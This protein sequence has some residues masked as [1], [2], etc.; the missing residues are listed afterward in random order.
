MGSAA[1]RRYIDDVT[2]RK[3]GTRP[4]GT[5]LSLVHPGL[6]VDWRD[7]EDGVALVV[8]TSEGWTEQLRVSRVARAAV[9][10]CAG[11]TEFEVDEIPGSLTTQEKFAIADALADT[12]TFRWASR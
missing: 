2:G 11:R 3:H 6:T 7:V 8:K 1:T 9:A 12:G 10:F 4:Y 5:A